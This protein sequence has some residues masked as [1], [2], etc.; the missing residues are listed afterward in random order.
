MYTFTCHSNKGPRPNLEDAVIALQIHCA[1][2]R[3]IPILIVADGVGGNNYGEVASAIASQQIA[4]FLTSRLATI[5]EDELGPDAII[6]L[7]NSACLQ[8][9]QCILDTVEQYPHLEGTSTTVVFAVI[10]NRILYICWCGD[11][12]GYV[13]G[14]DGIEQITTDH[15][16]IQNLMN[17][18]LI[19]PEQAKG[20]PLSHTI[21]R[22]LGSSE[23][24]Q[25]EVRMRRLSDS[26]RVVLFTDGITD[27]IEDRF[28]ADLVR[29]Y[30]GTEFEQLGSALVEQALRFSTTDNATV[31]ACS[32]LEIETLPST[33]QLTSTTGYHSS[34]ARVLQSLSKESGYE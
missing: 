25:P 28:L 15:S 6:D 20:H 24:C 31:A 3:V 33:F 13:I 17:E 4:S 19:T 7:L 14:D 2:H 30:S 11:S 34:V 29:D 23:H 21:T 16:A 32:M 5:P 18:G 10:I 8:A 12:R 9:N 27:V 26:D 1:W 22:Y